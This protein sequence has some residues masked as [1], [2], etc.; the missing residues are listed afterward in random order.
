MP[1][2]PLRID[3]I[4]VRL[5]DQGL[6]NL[7]FAKMTRSQITAAW[8]GNTVAWGLS[9]KVDAV[10]FYDP[11]GVAWTSAADGSKTVAGWWFEGDDFCEGSA[12]KSMCSTIW[13]AP[14]GAGAA[15]MIRAID[16]SEGQVRSYSTQVIPG[17]LGR[18]EWGGRF[19]TVP[20]EI[21]INGSAA[22][23]K[24]QVFWDSKNGEVL[25]PGFAY[26]LDWPASG[27]R[28]GGRLTRAIGETPRLSCPGGFTGLGDA[29]APFTLVDPSSSTTVVVRFLSDRW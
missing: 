16:L 1:G 13:S 14:A 3:R 18:R 27:V 17:D 7:G 12:A 25:G 2:S 8:I 19:A 23:S 20:V 21:T 29:G 9:G 22:Q 24:A 6:E 4:G 5:S 11:V 28:C 10:I 15:R 26:V